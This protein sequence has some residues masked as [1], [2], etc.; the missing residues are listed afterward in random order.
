MAETTTSNTQRKAR[1]NAAK[2]RRSTA[3]KKAAG[4]R[5]RRNA[6]TPKTARSAQRTARKTERKVEQVERNLVTQ[7]QETAE[8]AVLIPVGAALTAVDAV[9]ELVETYSDRTKAERELKRNVRKFERRGA[10]ARTKAE[11]EVKRTR[12][13]VER[14]LRQRR[15]RA[16]RAVKRN[17]TQ[18]K[19]QAKDVQAVAEQVQAGAA[20]VVQTGVTAA[21][22]ALAT[23]Q[24]R[25]AT[26]A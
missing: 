17:R 20:N 14:E 16:E 10:T 15:A 1:S 22:K 21:E 26:V 23:A 6:S 3:A 12:T 24:D 25:V 8:K 5:A 11:R 2:T 7:V 13:R 4:T 18:V 9:G 19:R